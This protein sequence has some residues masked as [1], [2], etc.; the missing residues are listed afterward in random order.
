MKIITKLFLTGIAAAAGALTSVVVTDRTQEKNEKKQ[1]EPY[2]QPI[3]TS[4]GI[5]YY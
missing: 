5:L 2:G 1:F 4:Y 3:E